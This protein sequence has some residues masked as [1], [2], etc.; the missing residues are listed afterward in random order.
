MPINFKEIGSDIIDGLTDAFA[1]VVKPLVKRAIKNYVWDW[2]KVWNPAIHKEVL[3]GLYPPIDLH[4]Q[5]LA[6][7]TDTPWDNV[8]VEAIKESM[9]ESAKEVELVLANLDAD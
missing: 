7:K 6:E 5:A 3:T 9:E 2:M 4:L 1:P 8:A